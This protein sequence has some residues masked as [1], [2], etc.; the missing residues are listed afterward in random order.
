M[1]FLDGRILEDAA[2]PGISP[3]ERTKLWRAAAQTL[4]KFHSVDFRKVGLQN[5]GKPG[6]FYDR[7]L[8]TWKH[9]CAVCLDQSSKPH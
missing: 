2:M 8:A 5:F 4:A 1:E 9:I 7:Q 6:G 3:E